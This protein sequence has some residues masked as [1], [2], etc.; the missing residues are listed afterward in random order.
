MKKLRTGIMTAAVALIALTG[1]A[2]N[3]AAAV[4]GFVPH[5]VNLRA[6]PGRDY[7]I[8]TGAYA[9][10]TLTVYGCT[11]GRQWCD[12][13][14]RGYRGWISGRDLYLS[15]DRYRRTN[16][17]DLGPRISLSIVSFNRDD[18]WDRYYRS[19]VFYRDYYRTH[20]RHHGRDRY[21]NS[22]HSRDRDWHDNDHH[23]HD[24]DGDR[25]ADYRGRW[26]D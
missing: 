3:A 5:N 21:D 17:I 22:R 13:N 6:G 15:G 23:D 12:V 10:M 19:K 24:R 20:P 25:Q 16:V 7:P 18:Y 9:N 8:V 4:K 2:G 1:F 11:A 26:N 14:Y